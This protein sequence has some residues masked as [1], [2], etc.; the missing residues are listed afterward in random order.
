MSNSISNHHRL[1]PI[2]TFTHTDL[3]S[4]TVVEDLKSLLPISTGSPSQQTNERQAD[5]ESPSCIVVSS[6]NA[7]GNQTNT[8]TDVEKVTEQ[9]VRDDMDKYREPRSSHNLPRKPVRASAQPTWRSSQNTN[10]T[11]NAVGS[12]DKYGIPPMPTRSEVCSS[13]ITRDSCVSEETEIPSSPSEERQ[14]GAK[15][16]VQQV[17][18]G[19]PHVVTPSW[20]RIPLSV[21]GL[22]ANDS[23]V[24]SVNLERVREEAEFAPATNNLRG[25]VKRTKIDLRT[26]TWKPLRSHRQSKYF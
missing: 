12:F 8:S 21:S 26:R 23:N 13:D 15:V 18:R 1:N 2:T 14:R 11:A 4:D 10:I 16:F 3:L 5:V 25:R 20:T 17:V 6:I 19:P 7:S 9:R 22:L 24:S